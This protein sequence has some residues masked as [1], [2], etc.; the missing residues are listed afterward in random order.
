MSAVLASGHPHAPSIAAHSVG[1]RPQPR[2]ARRLGRSSRG[3]P[4]SGHAARVPRHNVGLS[5]R[6]E[7][8]RAHTADP[9]HEHMHLMRKAI[10]GHRRS[11][12]PSEAIRGHRRSSRP[13]GGHPRPS[14]AIR[15]HQKQS[16]AIKGHPRPS[17]GHPR[18]HPTREHYAL[19]SMAARALCMSSSTSLQSAIRMRA[20]ASWH[21]APSL[22]GAARAAAAS[23]AA[24][25]ECR[26][27]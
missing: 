17:G 22:D 12:R 1:V 6:G 4:S 8:R 7:V 5:V 3:V 20:I 21:A 11:S 25:S 13:S 16:G 26:R 27:S 24:A 9:N 2:H 14:E 15:V 23:A 18:C 10:R 19:R